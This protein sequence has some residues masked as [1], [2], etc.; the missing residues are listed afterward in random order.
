MKTTPFLTHQKQHEAWTT[1]R[2]RT[3]GNAQVKRKMYKVLRRRAFPA[4]VAWNCFF[5]RRYFDISTDQIKTDKTALY[6]I[7]FLLSRPPF[8]LTKEHDEAWRTRLGRRWGGKL[9]VKRK[10]CANEESAWA[11]TACS[12]EGISFYQPD[13]NYQVP[14][15][16]VPQFLFSVSLAG[17]WGGGEYTQE[18]SNNAKSTG[19]LHI[20]E[21]LKWN[22]T[23]WRGFE[24]CRLL[25]LEEATRIQ[26]FP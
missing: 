13:K 23:Q 22:L 3:G 20:I 4:A 17:R 11:G 10:I 6:H 1:R 25:S 16:Y 18:V 12:T 19:R 24:Y 5:D 2:G 7:F 9:Q 8:S 26:C 14:G 15:T 21:F